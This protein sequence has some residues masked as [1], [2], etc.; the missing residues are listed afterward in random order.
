MFIPKTKTDLNQISLTGIRA[1]IMIGLLI[2]KPHSFDEIR[3]TFINLKIM[4]ESHSDDII[5]I[6]LNTIKLM[7]FEV[8]RCSNKTGFKYVLTK[9]PF[10]FKIFDKELKIIKKV[11]K[12]VKEKSDL[13]TLFEYDDLFKRIAFHVCDEETKETVLGISVFKYYDVD[14]LKDIIIDCQKKHTL[15]LLYKNPSRQN[16]MRK[17][18]IAQ[19]FV[20][21][22]DKFYLYGFDINKM[23]P[24][25]LHIRNIQSIISRKLEKQNFEP[26]QTKIKFVLKDVLINELDVNEQIIDKNKDTY[27][28]EGTFHNDFLATQRVLSFGDKCTVI[29]PLEFKKHIIK[30]IKEMRDVYVC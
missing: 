13:Q 14:L 23:K 15:D 20:F 29:E 10:S 24:V 25:V 6:D 12:S 26:K 22:S 7:G 1:L 17:Q 3:K 18:I 16:A 30:K 8:E 27:T 28:I 21:K 19:D 11:Y 2:K 4:G 5:R 9:Y